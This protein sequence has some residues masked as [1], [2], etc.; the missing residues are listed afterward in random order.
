MWGGLIFLI[1]MTATDSKPSRF[2]G[3]W[4]A[5]AVGFLV[6]TLPFTLYFALCESSHWQASVGKRVA[7]LRVRNRS[8]ERLTFPRAF[9]RNAI[10]FVPWELGH[11]M[12]QQAFYSENESF[13]IWL[14]GP[15][16]ISMIGPLWWIVSIFM[17]GDAPYDRWTVARVERLSK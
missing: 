4:I 9:I 16:L 13:P 12:A 3:P 2:S 10:K 14:W 1:V 15:A 8:G 17:T 5:Q 7:K 11:T 6:A